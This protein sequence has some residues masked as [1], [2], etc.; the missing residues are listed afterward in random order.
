MSGNTSTP[1]NE[2]QIHA[3]IKRMYA[4]SQEWFS[5]RDSGDNAKKQALE[6][7]NIRLGQSLAQYGVQAHRENGT[8]YASDGS[9]LFDKYRKYIYHSGGV[10]GDNPSLKQNEILAVLEK[11]EMILDKKKEDALY[12]TIQL[13]SAAS[14]KVGNL[15]NSAGMFGA[16]NIAKN[17]IDSTHAPLPGV[18]NNQNEAIH[19]GDINIYGANDDTVRQHQEINRRFTNEVLAQ[20]RI[21]R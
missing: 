3:I 10:A 9:L 4:N 1:T 18:T 12:R 13:L 8:W 17:G 14:D 20:L 21:K 19:F 5:A 6:D 11:G 15:M 2:E 16:F 7:E